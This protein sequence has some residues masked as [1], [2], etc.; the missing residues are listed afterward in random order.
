[1]AD[2]NGLFVFALVGEKALKVPV[3]V[4]WLDDETGAVPAELLPAGAKIIYDG[5]AGLTD[6]ERVRVVD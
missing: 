1:M 3:E 2:E 6:G 4:T 5:N